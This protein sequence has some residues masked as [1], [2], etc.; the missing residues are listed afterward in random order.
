[1][2]GD[3]SSTEMGSLMWTWDTE[4]AFLRKSGW[5]GVSLESVTEKGSVPGEEA[6]CTEDQR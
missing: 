3:C 2:R 6:V 5:S 4:K 1:M